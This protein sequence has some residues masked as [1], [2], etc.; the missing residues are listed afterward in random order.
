[1]ALLFTADGMGSWTTDDTDFADGEV[2]RMSRTSGGIGHGKH[3]RHG[4]GQRQE[5][6]GTRRVCWMAVGQRWNYT[7]GACALLC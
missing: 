7:E 6:E 3:G 4:R 2:V 5:Q 1:M